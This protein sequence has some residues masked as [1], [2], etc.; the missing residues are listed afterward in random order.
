MC[1]MATAGREAAQ[2]LTFA[3]NERGLRR[4]A[5]AASSSSVR[6]IRTGNERTEDNAREMT[7]HRNPN[8]GIARDH[9]TPPKKR[10]K[11]WKSLRLHG[12]SRCAHRAKGCALAKNKG[13][14]V[15]SHLEPSLPRGRG[16]CATARAGRQGAIAI[17][18]PETTSFIKL[19]R[20]PVADH[21]FLGSWMV[22]I[23]Q[24]CHSLR[25][26]PQ[27]RPTTHLGNRAARIREG[28]KTHGPAGAVRSRSTC[29]PECLDQ[30]RAQHA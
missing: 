8:R 16:R 11:L 27:G 23:H 28:R 21:V 14:R 5:Q 9:P 3:S 12:D 4:E 15:C 7:W 29:L 2:M 25:W 18:V 22:H 24:E 20:L 30:G 19:T 26:A 6:R 1:L 13:E 10:S 17:S